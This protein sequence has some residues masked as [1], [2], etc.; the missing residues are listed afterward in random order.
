MPEDVP[1]LQLSTVSSPLKLKLGLFCFSS[2]PVI[3][4][5]VRCH[6][7]GSSR[8]SDFFDVAVS[9]HQDDGTFADRSEDDEVTELRQRIRS[10]SLSR[11]DSLQK[12]CLMHFEEPFFESKQIADENVEQLLLQL[13]DHRSALD[14]VNVELFK[15][16]QSTGIYFIAIDVQ[17]SCIICSCPLDTDL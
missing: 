10:H 15:N 12:K 5:R 6:S 14:A 9:F 1:T 3:M 4:S 8:G 17:V 7:R 11:L 2:V 13:L 16:V